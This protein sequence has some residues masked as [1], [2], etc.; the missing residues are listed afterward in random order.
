MPPLI[1]AGAFARKVA[2]DKRVPLRKITPSRRPQ[3]RTAKTGRPPKYF[4]P[5]FL[6]E[7]QR[8]V[9]QTSRATTAIAGDF[10]M[11]HSVLARLIERE[12]WVRPE[13]AG[14]RRGLSP[15]M[16]LAA[17]VDELVGEG[18]EVAP[19]P[20]PL[21]ASGE[22]EHTERGE[23]GTGLAARASAVS[24]DFSALDRL[25]AAVLKELSVVESMRASLRDEP[26][27]P[28]DAERTARTLSVLT[29]T[30]SKLRRLRLG[31]APQAGSTHDDD[32]P[33]DID[34]FREALA[35]RIELFVA[36]RAGAPDAERNR[37]A[38]VD[39]AER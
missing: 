14:R 11:H 15:V 25:E 5:E 10:G 34:E 31:S 2:R 6:A 22:R 4:T 12:G 23:G 38:V 8:R 26:L 16:R 7:A 29:E 21:P 20:N 27:R 32:I 33:A 28:M 19:H 3:P 36:S 30:L 24:P 9:E 18:R 17:R 37:D 35:R 1:P 39:G 13:N